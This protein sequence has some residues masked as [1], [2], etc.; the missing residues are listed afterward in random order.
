MHLFYT[1]TIDDSPIF[2]LSEEESKHCIR[3]L[4]LSLGSKIILI[5]GKGG[6]YP[7][8]IIDDNPKR[9]VVS[10]K[11]IKKDTGKR[12]CHLH[13]AIAPTK[14]SDRIEWFMEKATEI[15][16]DEVSMIDCKN[17]ERKVVNTE[18]L[19]KVAISAIK[20]SLKAFLPKINE[21]LGFEK[22][23]Q[24]HSNFEGQK[25]IAHCDEAISDENK[26]HLKNV[27][28]AKQDVIILIGP[29]GDFSPDEIKYALKN[30]FKE[31]SL[32]G[33]RLRTETAALYACTVVNVM[34]E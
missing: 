30:G 32:G 8:E 6:W 18:R 11:E 29:E 5:D 25:F 20:Q 19:M 31:I 1:P 33:S 21:M 7:S 4:R 27:Y 28:T 2:T 23:I 34:N 15:G 16:I 10:I 17:A 13:L 9:C 12:N 24:Q 14:N 3:V 26:N 22:F